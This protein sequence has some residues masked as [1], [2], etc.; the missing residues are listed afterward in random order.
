MNFFFTRDAVATDWANKVYQ[1]D[2]GKSSHLCTTEEEGID[3]RNDQWNGRKLLTNSQEINIQ[4]LRNLRMP[5][6]TK[7]IQWQLILYTYKQRDPMG[8]S[9]KQICK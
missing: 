1:W 6:E 7:A 5:T 4:T 9:Q 8:L 3:G 2:Y